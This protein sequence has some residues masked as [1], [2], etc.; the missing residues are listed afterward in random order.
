[1]IWLALRM[2]VGDTTKWLGVLLGIVLSTFLITH[3]LSMFTGMMERSYALVTDIPEAELWIMDPEVEYVDEP[4][5]MTDTALQRVRGVSGVAWAM[6]LHVGAVRARLPDGSFRAVTV[7]GIDDATLVGAPRVLVA[8]DLDSLRGADAAIVDATSARTLLQVPRVTRN[9]WPGEAPGADELERRDLA[10]GDELLI[11]DRRVVITG[12]ADLGVRFLARPVL[13]TT[14]S[15][16]LQLSPAQ[17]MMLS[18]VVAKGVEGE[19][20][21]VVARR[22]EAAT[23]LRARTSREFADDTYWYYVENTGVVSR[24]ALMVGIGVV[25]GVSVSALLLFLFTNENSR[26]YA[27]FK[28]LGASNWTIAKM[29]LAQSAVAG[30]VG[31]GAGVGLS[32][33]M[34]RF[35]AGRDM[36]YTLVWWTLVFSLAATV[37]VCMIATVLSVRRVM[38]L[39]PGMVFST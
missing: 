32:V 5:P 15:R 23:G 36:P 14:Y 26:F 17:R 13:Y 4:M 16:A 30:V 34:G 10:V 37:L 39:E 2:L 25:T 38:R 12:V 29:V 24:I 1:M 3:M 8:G 21:E 27:T 33:V 7:V 31:Y 22:I 9:H 18:F 6:P 20:P 11:N 35:L 28:A 19:A